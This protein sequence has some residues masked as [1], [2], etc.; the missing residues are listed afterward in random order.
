MKQN[1]VL[2]YL[3]QLCCLGLEREAV[4]P[5]FLRAMHRVIASTNG[6]FTGCDNQLIPN[7]VYVENLTPD[8]FSLMQELYPPIFTPERRLGWIE[9]WKHHSVSSDVAC[10][11]ENFYK[12]DFYH[13]VWRSLDQHHFIMAPVLVNNQFAGMFHL[14]RGLGQKPFTTKEQLLC[15]QL[16]PY[17]SHALQARSQT[18]ITYAEQGQSGMII[19]N[20]RGHMLFISETANYLLALAAHPSVPLTRPLA[21]NAAVLQITQLC[22]N[23]VT[24]FQGK[25][26]SPPSLS[27]VNGR[28]R[29]I[30]RAYWLNALENGQNG[31]IGVTIEHREPLSLCLMRTMLDLPLSPSQKEVALLLA[32]GFSNEKIG[33]RLHIKLTTVKDH[34]NKI[35][36]KLDI[37]R[38]EE[39]LPKLL[40]AERRN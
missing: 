37:H 12:S 19:M 31:L 13:L 15:A 23:L 40:T 6:A 5:E 22:R 29:F 11:D 20:S 33:E 34:I 30:F 32:Q 38:R 9:F 17:L 3:R 27:H 25:H 28:G 24:V 35:F 4:I 39:L 2:A 1:N 7:F 14:C 8:L 18:A 21:E 26:A 36:L 16:M 10:L